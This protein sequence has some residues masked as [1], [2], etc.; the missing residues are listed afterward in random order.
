[1]R[2][3]TRPGRR[4]GVA[5]LVDLGG[6][7]TNSEMAVEM[8][9]ASRARSAS[10]ICNAPIVEGAVMAATEASGGASLD[11]RRGARPKSCRRHELD[12]ETDVDDRRSARCLI[13]HDGRPARAPVG[14][15]HQARQELSQPTIELALAADGPWIDAKSIVKVMAT[16]APQGHRAAFPRRGRW[17]RPRRSTRWSRSSSATSTR[18]RAHARTGWA[19]RHAGLA[20]LSPPGRSSASTDAEADV[21]RAS[22]S[23]QA[24]AAALRRRDRTCG[25]RAIAGAD[26]ERR[27]ATARRSSSSSWRCWR[28]RR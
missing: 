12:R 16:K 18:A 21:R 23:R 15:A 8:H 2:R 19:E 25:D 4:P 14:E 22:A 13:T 26:R 11:R 20:G 5:I 24:E 7:E 3:S 10:S 17:R 28:T 27:R 9:P 6:A 1:M